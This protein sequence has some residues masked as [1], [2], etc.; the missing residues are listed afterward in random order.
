MLQVYFICISVTVLALSTLYSVEEAY[1]S[2]IRVE[3]ERGAC[4]LLFDWVG[5]GASGC[6]GG[7]AARV[8]SRVMK[9]PASLRNCAHRPTLCDCSCVDHCALQVA[10]RPFL[11]VVP[12]SPHQM[13]PPLTMRRTLGIPHHSLLNRTSPNL[14]ESNLCSVELNSVFLV[15]S[16]LLFP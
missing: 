4:P 8:G 5:G 12:L 7:G 10:T 15:T 3:R 2:I 13:D 6:V 1:H 16:P 14:A 11:S 9:R